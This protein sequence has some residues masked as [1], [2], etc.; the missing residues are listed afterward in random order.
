MTSDLTTVNYSL[1]KDLVRLHTA[2]CWTVKWLEKTFLIYSSRHSFYNYTSVSS[3][4]DQISYPIAKFVVVCEVSTNF[5]V[6]FISARYGT[7][8]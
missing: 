8:F 6:S 4:L 5:S 3:T 1:Q 7:D 2:V